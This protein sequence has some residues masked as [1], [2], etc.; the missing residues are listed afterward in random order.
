MDS[1]NLH[2]YS[3]VELEQIYREQKTLYTS[4][5]LDQISRLIQEKRRIRKTDHRADMPY[6]IVML[7]LAGTGFFVP[8]IKVI[9]L[10]FDLWLIFCKFPP[11][12][13]KYISRE[14]VYA[15]M[16]FQFPVIGLV[17][18]IYFKI[19]QKHFSKYCFN[20]VICSL[21][22]GGLL[23]TGGFQF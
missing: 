1:E 23:L 21:V 9:P 15:M 5:E 11:V 17:M 12:F 13:K 20:A 18:G 2:A 6:C 3:L 16:S 8:V 14:T 10:I 22:L 19:I 7:V 4:E